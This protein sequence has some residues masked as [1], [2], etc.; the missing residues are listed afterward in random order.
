MKALVLVDKQRCEVKNVPDPTPDKDGIVIKVMAN[1]VCRSDWHMWM[2]G[3]PENR[4][5]GHEFSGVVEEV[6]KEVTRFKKGDRVIVPF[7]SSD[8]TCPHCLGGKSHLCDSRLS[9]GANYDGGYAD[10]VAI[11]KG[12]RNV[13]HL[14]EDLNFLD[15]SALGCR[16]M[17]A[18][19]GLVDR[20]Q[21][22]PGEWV[23][24]YGCGGLG[25]SAINIASTMGANIIGVDINDANLELAK[26]MGANYTINSRVTNPVNAIMEITRGGADVS[27]DALGHSETCV[28]SIRSLKNDGR[29]LQGGIISNEG[30]NV[31]IPV[32]EML[33]KEIRFISTYGMPVHRFSSLLPLVS[34]GKLT[35]GKMV[36]REVSLSEVNSLFESMSRNALSGT[37]VVTKFE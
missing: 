29:H 25:L 36:N 2:H 19:H 21:V 8:G 5:L 23:A 28:N 1:G 27:V 16:F 32:N 9:P 24:V 37:F 6:G 14:P 7:I 34:Q 26:Q 31:S 12:D 10:Y 11:P 20:V 13:I 4:I 35:P 33:K 18:Y 30:G 22:L 3:Q 15:A 17:T